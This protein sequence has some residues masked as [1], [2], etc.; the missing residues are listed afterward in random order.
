MLAA[1]ARPFALGTSLTTVPYSL[2][3]SGRI[4]VEV[5]LNGRSPYRFAIDSAATG[6]FVFAR[7][8]DELDLENVSDQSSI[9]RGVVASGTFPVVEVESLAVGSEMLTDIR[10]TSLPGNTNATVSLDGV[11]GIDFLRRYAIAFSVRDRQL[12]LYPPLPDRGA[13]SG[14]WA[15]IPIEPVRIGSTVEPLPYLE[16]QVAGRTIPALFDLGAGISVLNTPAALALGLQPE[17]PG[18]L[19]ELAGAVG[20][21][22]VLVRLSSQNLNTG[23]VSWNDETLLIADL[24]VFE[25]LGSTDEPLAI[26]GSGLVNQRDFAVDLKNNRLLVRIG[27]SEQPAAANP[28]E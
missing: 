11:L 5:A 20:A 12:R 6:S 21:A 18:E 28:F 8:R 19:A 3:A 27:M 9:V 10:L 17:N 13:A 16:I 23:N 2:E 15:T 4:V 25:T 7:A 1:C 22:P 24:D 14:D 26:L